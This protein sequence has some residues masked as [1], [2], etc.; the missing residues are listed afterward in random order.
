M[1]AVNYT[2]ICLN[3]IRLDLTQM[4][5]RKMMSLLVDHEDEDK[6]KCPQQCISVGRRPRPYDS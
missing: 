6:N 3:P 4:L 5:P 2:L 1:T